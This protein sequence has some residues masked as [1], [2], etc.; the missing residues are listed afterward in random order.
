MEREK[1]RMRTTN[2]PIPE[3]LKEFEAFIR[4]TLREAGVRQ[5]RHSFSDYE[6]G[7]AKIEELTLTAKQYETAIRVL[8]R[9]VRV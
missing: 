7:K 3:N 5:R 1:D 2:N 8:S 6:F 4:L 9:W